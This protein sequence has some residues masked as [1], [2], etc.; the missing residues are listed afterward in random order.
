MHELF[1][2]FLYYQGKS[3][4]SNPSMLDFPAAINN[5]NDYSGFPEQHH[6]VLQDKLAYLRLIPSIALSTKRVNIQNGFILMA[7]MLY[8]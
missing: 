2:Y 7:S 4:R 8:T 5:L 6:L 1:Y 3:V